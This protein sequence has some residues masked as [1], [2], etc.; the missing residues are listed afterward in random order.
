MDDIQNNIT[1]LNSYYDKIYLVIIE[2]NIAERLPS[3]TESLKG[4]N[5]ELFKIGRAHV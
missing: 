2:R 5:Y 4:L 1:F 3:I